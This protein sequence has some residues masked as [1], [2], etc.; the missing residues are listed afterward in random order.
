MKKLPHLL[1][2]FLASIAYQALAESP[3]PAPMTPVQ[4]ADK[5]AQV[6]LLEIALGKVAQS[7]STNEDVKKFGAFM[8]KSHT[9][10]NAML[11]KRAAAQ[12]ITIPADLDADSKAT[13]EK[14]SALKGVEFDKAYIPAMVQGHTEVLAMLKEYAATTAD[15]SFKKFAGRITPIIAEHLEHAKMVQAE[16]QKTGEL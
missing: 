12:K 10:I 7:N 2:V 15:A 8:V 1:L 5:V 6:D 16:L 14:L 4:F 3:A 11:T 9:Q 13:L